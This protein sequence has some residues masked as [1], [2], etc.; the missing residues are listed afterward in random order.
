MAK[1][2]RKKKTSLS[3]ADKA[4]LRRI[5]KKVRQIKTEKQADSG[6]GASFADLSL[7]FR[8]AA[9]AFA[10]QNRFLRAGGVRSAAQTATYNKSVADY[11]NALNA[12]QI[13]AQSGSIS[14]SQV[15]ELIKN[16]PVV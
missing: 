15:D 12:L 10:T 13:A 11:Q 7:A 1:R 8:T 6:T 9:A 16:T 5:L 14:Q 2:K 4:A 3:P